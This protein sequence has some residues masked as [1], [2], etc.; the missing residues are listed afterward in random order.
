MPR[1]RPATA[2]A[3]GAFV[4]PAARVRAART[5]AGAQISRARE[6]APVQLDLV[7]LSGDD[8]WHYGVLDGRREVGRL[9]RYPDARWRWAVR[10]GPDGFAATRA[11]AM[12]LLAAAYE[13]LRKEVA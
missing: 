5:T 8:G 11:A 3:G 1:V 2:V 7:K 12:R 4:W 10:W 6:A 13:A 9:C